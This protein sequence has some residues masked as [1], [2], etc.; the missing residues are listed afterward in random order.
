MG[1]DSGWN[2][3]AERANRH[4]VGHVL[5]GTGGDVFDTNGAVQLVASATIIGKKRAVA[6]KRRCSSAVLSPSAADPDRY[7]YEL[8]PPRTHGRCAYR[9]PL[10]GG[11]GFQRLSA[12]GGR[13]LDQFPDECVQIV[14][15]STG[16]EVAI[17]HD[18]LID[19]PAAGVFYVGLQ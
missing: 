1:R 15:P 12:L 10:R 5:F 3:P 8:P 16:D 14:G 17:D 9:T 18:L 11:Q 19:P 2:P 4:T 7:D 6:A 13:N